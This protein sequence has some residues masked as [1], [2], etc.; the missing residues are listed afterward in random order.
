MLIKIFIFQKMQNID[1]LLSWSWK[2]TYNRFQFECL[3][4]QCT[5]SLEKTENIFTSLL[6]SLITWDEDNYNYSLRKRLD[7]L[8]VQVAPAV[9]FRVH[10]RKSVE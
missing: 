1:M 10:T 7:V 5:S 3:I 4:E 6:R 8:G 9:A 2:K